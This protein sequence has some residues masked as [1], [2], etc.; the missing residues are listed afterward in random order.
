MP[1]AEFEDRLLDYTALSEAERAMV[2]AHVSSCAACGEFLT[3]LERV[4]AELDAALS[5]TAAP[6]GLA[7]RILREVRLPRPSPVPELLEG[8]G[9]IGLL[10][11]AIAV[12]F[13]TIGATTAVVYAAVAAFLAV[14]IAIS[15]RSLG[16]LRRS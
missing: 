7:P 3:A 11:L 8:I 16:D 13:V 15:A 5:N 12:V 9:W 14:A 10:L 1:C 6:V 4:D 2:A